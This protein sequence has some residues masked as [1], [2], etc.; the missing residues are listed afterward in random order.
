MAKASEPP[1]IDRILDAARIGENDDWEFKSGKGG[2]P[3]AVWESYS[4]M[5]NS[6]G[7]VIVLGATQRGEDVTLDGVD[8]GQLARW[9]KAFWDNHN[10][11]QKIN[12]PLIASGDVQDVQVGKSWLLAIR[13]RQA[14]RQERPIFKGMNPIDGT[15]KRRHEGD[16]R[17]SPEEVGRMIADADN[18]PADAR[19]LDGFGIDD[20]DEPSIIAFRNVFSA[21]A[22][23]PWQALSGTDQL[24]KFGAWRKDHETGKVGLTLA[25]LLMFGKHQAITSPG[26]APNYMVDFRDYRGRRPEERWG[27]RVFPDGTWEANLFQ[28]Y[29]RCW[30]KVSV[31]LKVPFSLKGVQRVDETPVHEALRE[32]VVNAMIHADYKVGGGIVIMRHDDRYQMENPGTLLVSQEQLRRG[33]VSECR[34]KSLQ[35]MFMLIG[36]GEQ[37]GSG[38]ARIQDGWKNQQWRAPRLTEQDG[39]DRVRLVM[40]MISLM[41]KK[42]FDDL[43]DRIGP[44]FDRLDQG[45]RIA[46]ATASIEGDVTNTRMQDLVLDHP[47]DITK[48]LRG[49]VT[50]GLLATDNQRRWTRYRLPT[51]IAPQHDL[52]SAESPDNGGSGSPRT[53]ADSPHSGPDS[54]RTEDDSPRNGRDSPHTGA[55]SPLTADEVNALRPIAEP[56]SR[57]KRASAAKIRGVI[58]QLCHGRYLT[59]D[60]LANL[61]NREVEGLRDR[62][63]SKMVC[64]G[65]LRFRHPELPNHPDQAYTATKKA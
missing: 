64:E 21:R 27:D 40:P 5:A 12:R 1:L 25:G 49:L 4:A 10:N 29:Q 33:G 60:Q 15:Y 38:F 24:E 45:E 63:L 53:G 37:A 14:T 51:A 35:R 7:G 11:R 6:A 43:R 54:P 41:P 50:K 31:D 62:N 65:L 32:A 19:I 18:T 56:V 16:Y 42:A 30:P 61:C 28:F 26:A 8:Q 47:A 22:P 34:N 20:L 3:D 13:V 59:A 23:H 2:F 48:V 58:L 46:L 52:F 39:P 57:Q 36:V 44:S 55:D 9:K 17:C